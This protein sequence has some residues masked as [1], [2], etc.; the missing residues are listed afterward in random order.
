MADKRGEVFV[1][2]VG[3][4][5]RAPT[6]DDDLIPANFDPSAAT[7]KHLTFR[8][9]G[10]GLIVRDATPAQVLI[11]G[12]LTWCLTYTVLAADVVPYVS[13][14]VGGFHQKAG[15]IKLQGYV[16]FS[17]AQKWTGS[18]LHKDYLGRDLQVSK[19]MA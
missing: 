5:Y 10:A 3:T 9:P 12:V 6:F 14:S 11:D 13:T 7:I 17:A 16:E 1:G 4:V 18:E 8:M 19:V 15:K 2:D